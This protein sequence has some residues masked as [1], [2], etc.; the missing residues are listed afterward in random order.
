MAVLLADQSKRVPDGHALPD[1]FVETCP[2]PINAHL[3][4]A[5]LSPRV[6]VFCE[7]LRVIKLLATGFR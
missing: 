4:N 5:D 1:S 3:L 2:S 7:F 6:A